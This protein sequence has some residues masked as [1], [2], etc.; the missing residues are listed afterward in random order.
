MYV[1]EGMRIRANYLL[2]ILWNNP[3]ELVVTISEKVKKPCGTIGSDLG[4][5]KFSGIL[6]DAN[7]MY[8]TK[9]AKKSIDF[10]WSARGRE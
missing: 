3:T 10:Y 6:P 7:K 2:P 4:L 5:L 8:W 9:N 1:K